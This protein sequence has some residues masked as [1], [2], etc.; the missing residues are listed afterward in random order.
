MNTTVKA[1]DKKVNSTKQVNKV[2]SKKIDLL[3]AVKGLSEKKA[4]K[5]NII[6]FKSTQKFHSE[7]KKDSLS[8]GAIRVNI[9][10]F[11]ASLSENDE[12]RLNPLLVSLLEKMKVK[13]NY[14]YIKA[15]FLPNSKGFYSSYKLLMYFR[16]NLETIQTTFK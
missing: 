2:E 9:L 13:S 8:L 12:N 7:F 4:K 10:N 15:N 14:E 16:T 11:N 5:E 1:T 6:N 3:K